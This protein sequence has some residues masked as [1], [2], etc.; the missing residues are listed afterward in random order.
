VKY[1]PVPLERTAQPAAAASSGIGD[2]QWGFFDAF[3]STTAYS[4]S[5]SLHIEEQYQV[6]K[7]LVH[8]AQADSLLR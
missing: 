2:Y 5:E 7:A 4:D 1:P 3:G 6:L 8:S